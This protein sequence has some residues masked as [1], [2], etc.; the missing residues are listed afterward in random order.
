MKQLGFCLLA[1]CGLVLMFT[2][3]EDIKRKVGQQIEANKQRA[4]DKSIEAS[5]EKI[6]SSVDSASKKSKAKEDKDAQDRNSL[7][8]GKD[9]KD[10]SGQ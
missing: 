9:D 10:D 1:I 5:Q 3:C 4:I 7:K 6:D 8:G 2:G